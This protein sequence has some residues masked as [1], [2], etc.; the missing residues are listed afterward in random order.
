MKYLP[1][2][3]EKKTI[4][5]NFTKEEKDRIKKF[6]EKY[7]ERKTTAYFEEKRWLVDGCVVTLYTSGKLVVQGNKCRE[8][9]KKILAELLPEKDFVLGIDEAGRG[10]SF[11]AFV[12]SAVLADNN[13]MRE[14]RDSKKISLAKIDEKAKAAQKNALA[15]LVLSCSPEFIDT[16]RKKGSTLN[17]LQRRFLLLAPKLF[18][19]LGIDFVTKADGGPIEGVNNVEFLIKGDD[20]CATIGAASIIAKAFREA[21][22][23]KEKRKTWSSNSE[24][25][26]VSGPKN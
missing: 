24:T 15:T 16:I 19:G 26:I 8:V 6:M 25:S 11:G 9:S 14:L 13:K 12:I 2:A 20:L 4:S 7:A 23:N 17:E 1:L 21:F 5:L 10:E 18:E 3:D 22:P